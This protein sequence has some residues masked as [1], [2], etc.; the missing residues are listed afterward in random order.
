MDFHFN[1]RSFFEL[2]LWL[3]S[4][5]AFYDLV[6][7]AG[8][9]FGRILWRGGASLSVSAEAGPAWVSALGADLDRLRDF[10]HAAQPGQSLR[11][12][13]SIVVDGVPAEY[14]LEASFA[15]PVVESETVE[16]PRA[17]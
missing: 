14:T 17:Q 11:V 2:M 15:P 12:R 8:R 3:F 5:C 4:I 13:G 16:A 6:A 1:L 9:A 10:V 7:R